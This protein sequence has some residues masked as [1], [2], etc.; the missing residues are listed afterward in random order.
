MRVFLMSVPRET[1]PLQKPYAPVLTPFQIERAKLGERIS[2]AAGNVRLIVLCAPAGFGKTT[3][4]LQHSVRLRALGAPS[5]W[6]T[7]EASHNDVSHFVAQLGGVLDVPAPGVGDPQ[8]DSGILGLIERRA[9]TADTFTLFLDDFEVIHNSTVLQLIRQLV[10]HTPPGWQTVIGSRVVPDLRLG[11]MRARGELVEIGADQLR[12]SLDEVRE[13][14]IDQRKLDLSGGVI[15]RLQ[16]VTEGWATA[17]WL[18]SVSLESHQEPERF[19]TTFSGSDAAI[20]E[21]LAEDVLDRQPEPLR[22]FL[23]RTSVLKQMKAELCDAVLEQTNSAEMLT[24]L[25]RGN[26]FLM[27]TDNLGNFRYHALFAD[28]LRAQLRQRS[29]GIIPGLHLRASRW[30]E[31]QGRP[32]P[33]IEHALHANDEARVVRLLSTH[34]QKLLDS[35]RFRL[36][37]RWIGSLSSTLLDAHP[38]LRIAQAWAMIFTHR[39]QQA[40]TL[41]NRLEAQREQTGEVWDEKVRTNALAMRAMLMMIADEPDAFR[42]ATASHA[43]LEP[44]HGLPYSLLSNSL[45]YFYAGLRQY[46]TVRMLLA[47]A[48]RSHYEIGSTF[49]LVI[50]ECLEGAISLCQGRLQDALARLRVATNQMSTDDTH[51]AERHALA[52]VQFAEALYESGQPEQAEHLLNVYLPMIRLI[53]LGDFEVRGFITLSRIAWRQGDHDRAF[54]VLGEMEYL[55]Q[56]DNIGRLMICADLE[57]ARLELLRGDSKASAACLARAAEF[58][59][60]YMRPGEMVPLH[61]VESVATARLRLR[62][63][64]AQDATVLRDLLGELPIAIAQARQ[65]QCHR[66]ALHLS[67]FWIEALYR[68]GQIEEA[69]AHIA[70]VLLAA[71][72]QGIVQ[73]FADE[74]PLIAWLALDWLRSR[75]STARQTPEMQTYAERLEAACIA[76]GAQLEGQALALS[77]DAVA[78]TSH[79]S[80]GAYVAEGCIT[81]REIDVLKLVAQGKSNVQIAEKLFVSENTVRTH[82]RNILSK[83]GASNRTEAVVLAKQQRLIA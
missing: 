69:K 60:H 21:F 24:Q 77:S 6:L 78:C 61:D 20:T 41:L 40:R 63:R 28:F 65:L 81:K 82:M 66:F 9:A 62:L 73:P 1:L 16:K 25:S 37:A 4:M 50:A 19:L 44:R 17:L 26:L 27:S 52:S 39:P 13:F 15:E 47:S 53:A 76:A 45:A 8:L 2:G 59:Q 71:A 11:R 67:L 54:A 29:P 34:A 32:V 23:L 74:G 79:R 33:A 18:A 42:V 46:D 83:L 48:R 43:Q 31:E 70:D 5:A 72:P 57:R 3:A 68:T 38:R 7:L 14:V 36:L 56:Q 58:D 80:T 55:G 35:G 64:G 30:Y 51:R 49:S 22:D 12:F 75:E 10:E